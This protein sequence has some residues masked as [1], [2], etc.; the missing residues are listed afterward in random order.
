MP[1]LAIDMALGGLGVALGQRSLAM[2]ELEAG[3][4]VAPFAPTLEMP[5]PYAL[6]TAR[7]ARRK[8]R[9]APVVAALVEIAGRLGR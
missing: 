4:L 3:R 9:L 1:A 6:V 5:S 8:R 2:Q 7:S